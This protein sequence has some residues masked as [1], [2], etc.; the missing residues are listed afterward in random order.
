MTLVLIDIFTSLTCESK[1]RNCFQYLNCFLND[2]LILDPW[3]SLEWK[4]RYLG[5][6]K[7]E[8]S[9][10][11]D[12]NTSCIFTA[13]R[14]PQCAFTLTSIAAEAAA[15]AFKIALKGSTKINLKCCYKMN[16]YLQSRYRQSGKRAHVCLNIRKY[17]S[18][19]FVFLVFGKFIVIGLLSKAAAP[20]RAARAA[21]FSPVAPAPAVEVQDSQ[22]PPVGI[23]GAFQ[24]SH[25]K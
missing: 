3:Y 7:K 5:I 8:T 2:H 20:A 15:A 13:R 12:Q 22:P 17:W 16:M 10:I 24:L 18:F 1:L 25:K 21:R 4:I 14:C 11:F 9:R 23:A 6:A 19:I